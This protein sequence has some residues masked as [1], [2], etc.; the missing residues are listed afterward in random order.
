MQRLPVIGH[1]PVGEVDRSY[2]ACPDP[3]EKTRRQLIWLLLKP[4]PP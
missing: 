1:L 3:K 4:G 2:R